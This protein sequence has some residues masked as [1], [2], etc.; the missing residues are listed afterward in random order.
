MSLPGMPDPARDGATQSAAVDHIII[1]RVTDLGGIKVR[2]AL[3]AKET[4]MVG[5]FIFFD[6]FGPGEFLTGK[7]LDVRPHPHIGL[8]T[9]TYLFDGAITHRDSLGSH[10]DIRPGELNLMKAGKAIVHS[11]R[12]PQSEREA[13]AKL[14][15]IQLWM[16]LPKEHEES[17]PEFLHHP[18]QDQPVVSDNGAKVTVVMGSLYG[19]HAKVKTL[20]ECFYAD[21]ALA[22]GAILPLDADFEERAIY[23]S[24][25]AVEIDNHR[26]DAGRM[27]IAR[28]GVPLTIT[29]LDDARLL[30]LG[31][32]PMDGPRYLWWNFVSSR[33]D[34]MMQAAEDWEQGR[35]P[36][37]PGDEE[38]F[39]PLDGA[40][41]K[42]KDKG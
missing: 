24:S 37:V 19:A 29:A 32:A 2:R 17:E 6:E 21:A 38:E 11:E 31:G 13:G 20:S 34:A 7:G 15:G 1:P 25:G 28:P 39:I 18:A 3:P 4:Q 41:P 30:L 12:T 8:S 42:L 26:Y 9:V 23:V 16:A 5:P 22:A 36:T 40:R 27:I 14:Y 10:Q 33:R 35:M